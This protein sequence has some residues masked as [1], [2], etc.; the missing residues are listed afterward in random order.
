ME[1]S[2]EMVIMRV[3]DENGIEMDESGRIKEMDSLQFMSTLV[4]LEQEFN[5]EFP[6]EFLLSENE[7]TLESLVSVIENHVI[8]G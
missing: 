4:S 2:I 7:L 1:K 6:D 8:K 3:L 5:M